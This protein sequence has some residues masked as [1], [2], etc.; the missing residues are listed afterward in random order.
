LPRRDGRAIALGWH[1][2]E[3]RVC[4]LPDCLSN[5]HLHR[6]FTLSN[7]VRQVLAMLDDTL[8]LN[9]RSAGFTRETP[10]L[11]ALPELDSMAVAALIT[12]IEETFGVSIADDDID[13]ST[14]ESVGSLSDF[15][16]TK[17][18]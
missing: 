11:G 5:T 9:G 7:H 15:I 2:P 10:L 17:L 14:F 8:N 3:S 16:A 13:G 1:G 6:G 18:T 12:A 4:S